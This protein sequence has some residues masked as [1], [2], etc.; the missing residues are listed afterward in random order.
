MLCGP[1]DPKCE[2]HGL[3]A[4]LAKAQQE[5]EFQD[6]EIEPGWCQADMSQR[7]R[8]WQHSASTR[9]WPKCGLI[10]QPVTN[11]DLPSIAASLRRR[12]DE[13]M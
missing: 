8:A 2:Y 13:Q 6:K 12:S 4:P 7:F 11:G 9:E 10:N 5:S 3:A 1:P